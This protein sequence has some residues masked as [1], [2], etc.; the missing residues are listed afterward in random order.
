MHL[1]FAPAYLAFLLIL[2]M[3]VQESLDVG[4]SAMLAFGRRCFKSSMTLLSTDR[5]LRVTAPS[6]EPA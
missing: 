5:N 4:Q 1:L 3:S 6:E 2:T